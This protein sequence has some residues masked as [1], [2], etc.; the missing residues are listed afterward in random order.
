M[1]ALD[2]KTEMHA[3]LLCRDAQFLGSTLSVLKHLGGVPQTVPDAAS[4]LVAFREQIRHC[5]H[6]LARNR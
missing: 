5:H 3:L 1:S 6:G 4:A 2:G